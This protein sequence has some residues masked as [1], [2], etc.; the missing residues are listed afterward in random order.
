SQIL[1]RIL[2]SVEIA[3]EL[4][5]RR[6][7][8]DCASVSKLVGGGIKVVTEANRIRE[9]PDVFLITSQKMPASHRRFAL[10]R[11]KVIDVGLF[12]CASHFGGF[13]GVKAHGNHFKLFPCLE[14][15][16]LETRHHPV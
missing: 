2:D 6:C 1:R 15:E 12:F 10:R 7:N 5:L 11:R 4:S 3:S 8:V 13:E 14:I 9:S 16:H